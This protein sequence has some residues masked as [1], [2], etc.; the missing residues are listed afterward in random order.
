MSAMWVCVPSAQYSFWRTNKLVFAV[1]WSNGLPFGESPISIQD[2]FGDV[3]CPGKYCL[4]EETCKSIGGN[5]SAPRSIYA[6]DHC[7]AWLFVH[8][9]PFTLQEHVMT[10]KTDK[11]RFF[12]AK[13]RLTWYHNKQLL[14]NVPFESTKYR[15]KELCVDNK[16]RYTTGDVYC[17]T[18]KI[19][20]VFTFQPIKGLVSTTLKCARAL[21][22]DKNRQNTLFL[23]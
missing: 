13:K 6:C 21:K 11:T 14:L 1:V 20:S 3:Y 16:V 4:N 8:K 5:V 23:C 15:N 2:V 10:T 9:V 12:V 19:K 7:G 17:T 22:N 18:C